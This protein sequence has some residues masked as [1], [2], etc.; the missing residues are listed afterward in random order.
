MYYKDAI[1]NGFIF[2]AKKEYSEYV[3]IRRE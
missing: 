1:L 2:Q 3:K